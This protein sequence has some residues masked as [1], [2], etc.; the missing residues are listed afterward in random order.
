MGCKKGNIYFL[1]SGAAIG[2]AAYTKYP[3]VLALVII[4]CFAI[5]YRRD[6]FKNIYFYLL[7]IISALF[8]F[9]WIITN[10]KFYG[11][12][13]LRQMLLGHSYMSAPLDRLTNDLS[14]LVKILMS[15]GSVIFVIVA[16]SIIRFYNKREVI[17]RS[18]RYA[19]ILLVSIPFL[20]LAFFTSVPRAFFNALNLGHIPFT[21]WQMGVLA[22]EPWHFYLNRLLELSP[23]YIFAFFSF[24]LLAKKREE[25]GFL[26]LTVFII[27]LSYIV[28]G[29]YQS[30]YILA[31]VPALL[32][33][34]SRTFFMLYEVIGN[35]RSTKLI[36]LLRG[37][38]WGIFLFFLIKTIVVDLAIAV[39]NSVA[40]F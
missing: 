13:F 34:A 17:S 40:Y 29:N 36:Y 37:M 30:R 25:D 35:M 38:A 1:A 15:L 24:F 11:S 20:Y 14:T 8:M 2:L 16:W 7:F 18:A 33:L 31:A 9:P 4:A 26:L 3:G 12:G 32:I 22:K 19:P 39:P 28:W 27:L 23:F 6:L 21:T 10:I 5:I